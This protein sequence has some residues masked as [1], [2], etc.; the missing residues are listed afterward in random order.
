MVRPEKEHSLF[1]APQVAI[2]QIIRTGFSLVKLSDMSVQRALV[3][4]G[5]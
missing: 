2:R 4:V 1:S 5:F 3:P